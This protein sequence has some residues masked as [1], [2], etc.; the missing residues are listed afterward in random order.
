MRSPNAQ[1]WP[2]EALRV[3]R[4]GGAGFVSRR[5]LTENHSGVYLSLRPPT[6]GGPIWERQRHVRWVRIMTA[7]PTVMRALTAL[8][9]EGL[10]CFP[11]H[12]NKRPATPGGYKN[13]TS[14]RKAVEELWRRYPAPLIGV[15]TGE[16]S[17]LDVLDIDPRHGGDTWFVENKARLPM[18]RV[19]QTQGG[20][21]S[22]VVSAR[23]GFAVQHW[24][25]CSGCR[26]TGRGRLCHLVARR[27]ASSHI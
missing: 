26:C 14:N 6:A 8:L 22:P 17:G 7:A 18:T 11:C 24:T 10:P 25:Y 3:D 12:A 9:D 4:R 19:H 2:N 27:W 15:P 23:V 20:G 1:L 21:F 13:A 5:T 16:M